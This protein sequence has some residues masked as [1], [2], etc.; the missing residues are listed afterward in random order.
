MS[1]I[2]RSGIEAVALR[3][4]TVPSPN[5]TD[6]TFNEFPSFPRIDRDSDMLGFR[7]QSN[8]VYEYSGGR[9]GTSGVYSNPDG[10]LITGASL[11]GIPELPEFVYYG[12]PQADPSI[13]FDQFPGA[14]P[15]RTALLLSKAT[16]RMY[17]ALVRQV[18]ISAIWL[19]TAANPQFA[20]SQI[21]IL[22]SLVCLGMSNLDPRRRPLPLGVKLFFSG[23]TMKRALLSVEFISPI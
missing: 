19:L 23:S 10:F 20:L 4:G 21:A 3:G 16:G 13:R 6:A 22:L 18:F 9:I 8:P 14:P 15:Q 5:N 7:G 2:E 12:V 1:D 11:L 17:P